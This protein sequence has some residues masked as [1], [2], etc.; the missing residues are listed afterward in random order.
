ML[1]ATTTAHRNSSPL[2]LACASGVST[3]FAW[4]Q[5]IPLPVHTAGFRVELRGSKTQNTP[6]ASDLKQPIELVLFCPAASKTFSC[7]HILLR[8]ARIVFM[9]PRGSMLR[10]LLHCFRWPRSAIFASRSSIC[11]PR[12]PYG[13]CLHHAPALHL[14]T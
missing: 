2:Q 7:L 14:V 10:D 3:T 5:N 8:R 13:I 12:L 11:R 9:P 4:T 6:F 1:R